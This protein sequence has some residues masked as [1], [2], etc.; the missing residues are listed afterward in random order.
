MCSVAELEELTTLLQIP[1]CTGTVNRGSD[2]IASGVVANDW[3]AF[4][5]QD[6]TSTELTVIDAIFKLAEQGKN[7]FNAEKRNMLIDTLA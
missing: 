1:L 7:V 6:T 5:G 3:A 2:V 4:C